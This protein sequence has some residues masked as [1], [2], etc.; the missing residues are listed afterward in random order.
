MQRRRS[1]GVFTGHLSAQQHD[2]C[3]FLL[4]SPGTSV[5]FIAHSFECAN[6]LPSESQW[7]S[8]VPWGTAKL[9]TLFWCSFCR[10]TCKHDTK[11]KWLWGNSWCTCDLVQGPRNK[12]VCLTLMES[13]LEA[14]GLST[15]PASPC[16]WSA[17]LTGKRVRRS[18]TDPLLDANLQSQIWP[19]KSPWLLA[20]HSVKGKACA[21]TQDERWPAPQAQGS[22][23]GKP[24][25][26][27][28]PGDWLPLSIGYF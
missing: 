20:S 27:T 13:S 23:L 5:L 22:K 19:P 9:P 24:P 21:M 16:A 25:G 18:G 10:L 15:T 7:F 6:K 14:E 12:P 3:V 28:D 26:S 11:Y 1:I 4:G 2:S 17:E 8:V